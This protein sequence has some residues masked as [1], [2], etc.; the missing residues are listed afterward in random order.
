M[1]WDTYVDAGGCFSG[2]RVGGGDSPLAVCVVGEYSSDSRG[3]YIC[4][5]DWTAC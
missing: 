5:V 2:L 4:S 1:L 3:G